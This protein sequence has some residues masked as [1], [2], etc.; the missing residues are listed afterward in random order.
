M[1]AANAVLA[2]TTDLA[3]VAG[4]VSEGAGFFIGLI[5]VIAFLTGLGFAMS[6]LM[7]MVRRRQSPLEVTWGRIWL[8]LIMAIAL[9][10]IVYVPQHKETKEGK[11]KVVAIG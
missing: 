7:M 8:H 3:G 1:L 5:D 10:G 11:P 6:A 9:I 2:K 4:N